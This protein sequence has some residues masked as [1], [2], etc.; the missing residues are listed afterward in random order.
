MEVLF[1]AG[2]QVRLGELPAGED[3][4]SLIRKSGGDVFRNRVE[5]AEDFF[6]LQMNRNLTAAESRT[7]AGRVAFARKMSQFIGVVPDPVLRETLISR[8]ATR[9]TIPRDTLQQ[10]VRSPGTHSSGRS[11]TE[12]VTAIA[13]PTLRHDLAVICKAAL[14]IPD[15]LNNIKRQP[16]KSVLRYV[17]GSELLLKIFESDLQPNEPASIAAFFASLPNTEASALTLILANKELN[18]Q[19]GGIYWSQLAAGELQ[20]RKRQ[21][22]NV[23][24]LAS[25]DPVAQQQA[26]DELKE[27]LDL[28]S[29]FTDISR[30]LS[31]EE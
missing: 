1:G 30:L 3:P 20:R 6:D 24:R 8:L 12:E 4:D 7:T 21:L 2:L 23:R 10:M 9:L 5:K 27:V 15:L 14:V 22:E 18:E 25:D 17:E 11:L 26:I 29:R 19:M 16:W 31:R 13:L 28:E